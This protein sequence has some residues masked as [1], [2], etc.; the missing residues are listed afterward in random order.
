MIIVAKAWRSRCKNLKH[1]DLVP[2]FFNVS[3]RDE[4]LN[5]NWFLSLEDALPNAYFVSLGLTPLVV[6]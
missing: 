1:R 5:V 6:N 2:E 4:C 3:F